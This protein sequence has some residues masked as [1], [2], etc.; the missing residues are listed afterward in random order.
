MIYKISTIKL[1]NSFVACNWEFLPFFKET[2]QLI[3]NTLNFLRKQAMATRLQNLYNIGDI[4]NT[5]PS[6]LNPSS[7][8]QNSQSNKLR[9]L[10]DLPFWNVLDFFDIAIASSKCNAFY[11]S[12]LYLELWVEKV[13]SFS[14]FRL[15]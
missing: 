11:T 15:N 8:F 7:M 10:W 13:L 4:E 3:L 1:K 12:F 2:I 6:L 14:S 5:I 9:Y